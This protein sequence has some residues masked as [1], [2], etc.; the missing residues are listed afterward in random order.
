MQNLDLLAWTP[1]P[2]SCSFT[3]SKPSV[4]ATAKAWKS[5]RTMRLHPLWPESSVLHGGISPRTC[6]AQS[7]ALLLFPASRWG[8]CPTAATSAPALCTHLGVGKRWLP[9]T[10]W[11]GLFIGVTHLQSWAYWRLM[12]GTNDGGTTD[13]R[14]L[15]SAWLVVVQLWPWV[16]CLCESPSSAIFSWTISGI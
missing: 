15:T 13:P 10:S 12:G 5:S 8:L 2:P 1:P 7:E 6:A 11:L 16:A 3:G 9:V 14:G 4:R